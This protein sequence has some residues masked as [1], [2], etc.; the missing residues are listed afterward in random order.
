M[1]DPEFLVG[2]TDF[3]R[4]SFSAKTFAKMKDLGP[5]WGVGGGVELCELNIDVQIDLCDHW[6]E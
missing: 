6:I 3:R 4:G 2:G 5:V 1:A